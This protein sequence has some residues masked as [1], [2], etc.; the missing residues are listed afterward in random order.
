M[1]RLISVAR[2][3]QGSQLSVQALSRLSSV[4]LFL[5]ASWA[6]GTRLPLVALQGALLALPFT[7]MES[8]VGRPV[9]AG[10]LPGTGTSSRGPAARRSPPSSRWP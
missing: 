4:I 10:L 8:L 2:K 3:L 1:S 7:L 6:D 5:L 9:S